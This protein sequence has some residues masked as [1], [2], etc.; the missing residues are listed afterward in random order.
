VNFS[1]FWAA[2][3]NS[4]V[5]CAE[6]ARDRPKQLANEI[7]SIKCRFLQSKS[8]PSRF[9]R[10]LRTPVS[11]RSTLRKSGYLSAVVLSSMKMVAI[12]TDVRVIITS[13]GDELLRNV[14]IDD[15][16]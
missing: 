10:G 14:N 1:R 12:C 3:R 11:K 2:I 15:L 16:E 4:K 13:T 8:G 7:F 6:I 5:N 9:K